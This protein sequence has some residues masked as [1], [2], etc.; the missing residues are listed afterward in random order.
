MSLFSRK[1]AVTSPIGA[2]FAAA[3]K[4]KRAAYVP[5]ITAGDPSLEVTPL[6]LEQLEDAGA[7]VIELGVPFS[8]PMADGPVNQRAAYRAL[9]AGTTLNGILEMI[10]AHRSR[11][12]EKGRPRVPIVLFTYFNPIFARGIEGFADQASA[13]GVDGVLC[14]DAPPDETQEDLVPALR[15]VGI[16]PIFLLAPTSPVE[17]IKQVAKSSS[18]FVYYVSRTGITGEKAELAPTL[19][20][21]VKK[22]RRRVGL[23]VAVG[24]GISTPEQVEAVGAVADGVVVGSALVRVVEETA[25]DGGSAQRIAERLGARARLLSTTSA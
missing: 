22:L 5:Y 7:D 4:Q 14:V 6:L 18:G 21:D 10:S 24:F 19:L 11:S 23:P 15:A 2:A 1:S 12:E 25:A 3:A 8:D 16:D 20:A 17:R 9:E 13:A